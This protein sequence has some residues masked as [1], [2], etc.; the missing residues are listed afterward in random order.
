MGGKELLKQLVNKFDNN[1]AYYKN[2][3]NNYNENSCRMEYI[4]PLLELLGWDISNRDTLLPQYREVIT[5]DYNKETGRP[6]Y[7]M[8]LSGVS[9]FFIEAKKPSIN[10][11]D[12]YSP[13]YQARS[14]G[15][16]AKH[17]ISVLTNFEYLLIYDTTIL[18]N[19]KDS[20]NVA[21]IKKYHYTDYLDKFEEIYSLISKEIV[22]TG[23]FDK[24]F[25]GKK[26]GINSPIDEYFLNQINQW[27][28]N[29]GIYL[30]QKD[31]FKDIEIVNDVVQEF[32]NQIVFLRI[33]E[34]R[35]LPL[36]HKLKESI[37]DE[38]TM[39]EELT[40][41]F[42]DADKRYNSGLF[43]GE[44]IIFNLEN[45]I[46]KE[47]VNDLYFPKSP[48]VFNLIEPTLLGQIY[49]L[50]LTQYLGL[51]E[52]GQVVLVNKTRNVNRDIVTT[53]IE[54]VKYMTE[55]SLKSLCENKMPKEI[56]N[57]KVADIACGSGIYLIE[58][59][60]Y[61]LNYCISWYKENKIEHL[62]QIDGGKY[63]L[64]LNEKK[65][66]L[67]SCIYGI[68]IDIYAVEVAKFSLLLKLLEDETIPSVKDETPI[69][70]DLTTNILP[71]NSLI[72][73]KHISK[74][75]IE[76]SRYLFPFSWDLINDGENFDLIIG[77]PPYVKTEDMINL[78]HPDELKIYKRA[79]KSSYR[80]FDKYFVFIERAL[81][82]IKNK[83]FLCY[84]IP[85]KF[86][87]I[88]SGEALRKLITEKHYVK[89]FIDF[90][91]LQL[92]EDKTIYSSIILLQKREQTQFNYREIDNLSEWWATKNEMSNEM[93]LHYSLLSEKPWVLV[94]NKEKM[95]IIDN[96]YRNSVSLG[97]IVKLFNGI[98][99]SAE[100]PPVYWFSTD[101]ILGEDKDRKCFVIEKFDNRYLIEKDILK[102]YFKPVK[103]SEK[104]NLTYDILTTNKW[105]IF[106]YDHN[107]ELYELE[108]M[109]ERFSNTLKYLKDRYDLLEPKQLSS[110]GK[111]RDVPLATEDTWYQYGRDQG[112]TLF[113]NTRKLIVGVLSQMP[114]YIYD[115]KNFVIASGGTAGYCGIAEKEDS[116]Y[117]LEFIQA[118]MNH[119]VIDWI[120]SIIGSDFEG[121]FYSRG[122]SVL[123]VVPVKEIDFTNT[124]QKQLYDNVVK[125]TQEVYMINE[126]LANK[127]PKKRM[128]ELN[129][130][131]TKLIN[132]IKNEIDK[133][134]EL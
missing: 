86:S 94:P 91:S 5:E 130:V 9:K 81:N 98:Q 57:I 103:K 83:G 87:K 38:T 58:A 118:Y 116:Q 26:E 27:R 61:L 50:F 77:N 80:Q 52:Y 95:E 23:N 76:N 134:L 90:G 111:G 11:I 67:L 120:L 92:F 75:N 117:S 104:K 85:N 119:P 54:I 3:S 39:K 1:F 101:E 29:L 20:S 107:G 114:L 122:T 82:K 7:S 42:K 72:D 41:I 125:W 34:D 110:T 113:N 89:E 112:L 12:N 53:P 97:S 49:E 100:R 128:S 16:S 121:N 66:I 106:P 24:V 13:A 2:T 40:K 127:V 74:F 32:I 129:Y 21:L 93:N 132:D 6:D 17:K 68:D 15:W 69:L 126:E 25:S 31:N 43:S 47:I 133:V 56:L 84:I 35:N 30:Y 123:D 73:D 59:Y 10:L 115:N 63:K 60:N 62:I 65:N 4:D 99:T 70:P 78:L 102:P 46:I 79:Y 108:I 105:I 96:I 28:L 14:Y 51:N 33:C 55:K 64:P 18:P 48:Y 36:Y 45:D 19:E 8:T 37:S 131:K 44:Y 71:G 22:Y 109:E 88:K 124:Y